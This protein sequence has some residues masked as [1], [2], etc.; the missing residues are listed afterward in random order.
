MKNYRLVFLSLILLL[1]A[2]SDPP[3][4]AR[5]IKVMKVTDSAGQDHIIKEPEA[6]Y[7]NF[8][9]SGSYGSG[10]FEAGGMRTVEQLLP[11]SEIKHMQ[12][13]KA[14]TRDTYNIPVNV[15]GYNIKDLWHAEVQLP[16]GATRNVVLLDTA[17]GWLQGDG[18]LGKTFIKLRDVKSLDML[19]DEKTTAKIAAHAALP[20]L[21]NLHITPDEGSPY[22]ALESFRFSMEKTHL[23]IISDQPEPGLKVYV[24]KAV[25]ALPW[26]A[27]KQV[28]ISGKDKYALERAADVTFA[29]GARRQYQLYA[30]TQFHQEA[31]SKTLAGMKTIV[32]HDVPDASSNAASR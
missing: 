32:V 20:Q 3:P 5:A 25:V 27:L 10:D 22:E 16:S 18:A 29:D 4:S 11:W 19:P 9:I 12:V 13:G 24:G 2:C 30:P 14:D 23:R 1:A 17:D 28:D 15:P 7:T 6:D 8:S 31:S 21:V 26:A